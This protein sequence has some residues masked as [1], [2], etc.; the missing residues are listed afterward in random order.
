M[1]TAFFFADA[2][3]SL[4]DL[5]S[6]FCFGGAGAGWERQTDERD[7]KDERAK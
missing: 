4:R 1:H 7:R 6:L 3:F 2:D 5:G